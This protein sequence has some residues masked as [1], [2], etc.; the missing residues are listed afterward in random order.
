MDILGAT[1]ASINAIVTLGCA[2]YILKVYRDVRK[3]FYLAWS[4]GFVIYGAQILIRLLLPGI[5]EWVPGI[6]HMIT[7]ALIIAGLED[8]LKETKIPLLKTYAL[9]VVLVVFFY[10]FLALD[11]ILMGVIFLSSG[12]IIPTYGTVLM[13]RVYGHLADNILIGW[14]F[15]YVANIVFTI[16]QVPIYFIDVLAIFAKLVLLVGIVNPAFPW[17]PT[18][19]LSERLEKGKGK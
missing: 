9:L 8:V 5:S 2:A 7:F 3:F 19:V 10:L 18:L 15:L 13:R 6:L 4:I 1:S 14:L 16:G 11:R 12:W 17:L